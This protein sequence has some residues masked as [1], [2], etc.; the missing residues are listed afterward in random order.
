MAA[1]SEAPAQTGAAPQSAAPERFPASFTPLVS[2]GRRFPWRQCTVLVATL[3]GCQA[4]AASQRPQ[5]QVAIVLP[6]GPIAANVSF[7]Q[8]VQLGE[9]MARSCGLEPM[10][11]D[12]RTMPWDGDPQDAF[13]SGEVPPLLVAPFAADLRAFSRL[14]QLSDSQVLLPFQ[15]GASLQ[16]LKAL[17][18]SPRLWPLVPSRHDDL[19]TLA[20][21]AIS[22][23]WKRVVVV[24]DPETIEASAAA[25]FIEQFQAVGGQV[26][27]YTDALVQELNP[28][29][30]DRLRLLK[31]DLTWQAPDALVIA[32]QP[33]G[34]LAQVLRQAQRDGSIAPADPAW[35]WPLPPD[36]L[37]NLSDQ[38]W[39]QLVLQQPAVGPGWQNFS[40][41][42]QDRYGHQPDQLAAAGFDSARLLALASVARAPVTS[43]GS[44][45]TFGWIDP[46]AQPLPLCDAIQRRRAGDAVRLEG[47]SGSL[48]LRPAQ[49]PSGEAVTRLLAAQ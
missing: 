35:I 19:R 37:T 48:D 15:R 39:P 40:R 8:G 3:L 6:E 30:A 5:P 49:T 13:P 44:R 18:A 38:P 1:S 11:S 24:S 31:Q 21:E 25:P 2:L 20:E 7:L 36:Q 27:S 12:W 16:T 26:L 17:D 45:D 34:R 41:R 43:E 33:Q 14:A 46:E 47:A 4:M 32:A 9:A 22:R 42:F 10:P 28:A 23:G 29:N